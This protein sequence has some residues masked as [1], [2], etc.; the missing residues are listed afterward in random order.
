MTPEPLPQDI[1]GEREGRTDSVETAPSD[2]M[3]RADE[4]VSAETTPRT[5]PNRTAADKKGA[6]HDEKTKYVESQDTP[7]AAEAG[8]EE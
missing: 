7:A 4:T 2:P 3:R 5:A 1:H 8:E 6:L